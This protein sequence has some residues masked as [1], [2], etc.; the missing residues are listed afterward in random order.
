M[1]SRFPA[2]GHVYHD[3]Q[4]CSITVIGRKMQPFAIAML[5]GEEGWGGGGEVG[6]GGGGSWRVCRDEGIW[7]VE[8]LGARWLCR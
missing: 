8:R 3:G 2:G 4:P 7:M 6:R 5:P 1:V